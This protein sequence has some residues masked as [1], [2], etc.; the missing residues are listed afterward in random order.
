MRH[1]GSSGRCGRATETIAKHEDSEYESLIG[2]LSVIFCIFVYFFDGVVKAKAKDKERSKGNPNRGMPV[3]CYL[4]TY[5]LIY[6]LSY[7]PIYFICDS[8]LR[9]RRFNSHQTVHHVRSILQGKRVSLQRAR[10][11]TARPNE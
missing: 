9:R 10:A 7:L 4:L 3:L 1:T 11:T 5:L 2:F 8:L 6:L